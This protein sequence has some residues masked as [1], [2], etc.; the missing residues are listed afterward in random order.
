MV[1][2]VASSL[3][4]R[5]TIHR[6]LERTV[7][8]TLGPG[9]RIAEILERKTGTRADDVRIESGLD[10]QQAILKMNARPVD[11]VMQGPVKIN[12]IDQHLQ[13]GRAQAV[14]TA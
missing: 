4:P 3:Q 8:L 13:Y 2:V 1:A 6:H 5:I 11:G 9:P 10:A 7:K 12:H 14:G